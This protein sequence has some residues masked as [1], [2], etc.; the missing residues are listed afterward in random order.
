MHDDAKGGALF[1]PL[2][3]CSNQQQHALN[4]IERWNTKRFKSNKSTF[5]PIETPVLLAQLMLAIDEERCW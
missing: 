2:S 4:V 3:L 1:L 5:S